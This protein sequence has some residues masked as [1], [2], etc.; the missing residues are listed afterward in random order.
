MCHFMIEQ[1]LGNVLVPIC[2]RLWKATFAEG[3]EVQGVWFLIHPTCLDVQVLEYV[4]FALKTNLKHTNTHKEFLVTTRK[5][6]V[7]IHPLEGVIVPGSN[8]M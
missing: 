2:K 4:H 5:R 3:G 6:D 7:F 1:Y 8:D